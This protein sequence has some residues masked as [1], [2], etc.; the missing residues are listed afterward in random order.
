MDTPL[1]S[2]EPLNQA[3]LAQWSQKHAFILLL[4]AG[5]ALI[6][7]T[8]L[9]MI[10]MTTAS[11]LGLLHIMRSGK[12]K[13]G[14]GY[15]NTL[16]YLRAAGSL[17]LIASPHLESH[18]LIGGVLVLLLL[19]G[20]DGWIARRFG[21]SSP[22]GALLDQEA[23]ALLMLCLCLLLSKHD[24][25]GAWIM[26]PGLFRPLFVLTDRD[27]A[28]PVASHG[29]GTRF[30]RAVGTLSPLILTLLLLPDFPEHLVMPAAISTTIML[31]GSF[32][33][34]VHLR[35][36]GQRPIAP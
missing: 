8:G 17:A 2:T 22:E 3:Q 25:L 36:R 15:A 10:I 11:F 28:T 18:I 26:A 1:S 12:K 34:S 23:D 6:E 21:E 19:D 27:E 14:L 5:S 16:S 24:P 35:L 30:T 29:F 4:G 13:K 31:A 32:L 7:G 33:Y 20:L 9:L